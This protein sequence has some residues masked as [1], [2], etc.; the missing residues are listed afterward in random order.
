MKE[1]N[2]TSETVKVMTT[3]NEHSI[4]VKAATVEQVMGVKGILVD[5]GATTHIVKE[6]SKF[7]QL[8]NSC[9]PE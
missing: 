8:D 5:T 7:I 6:R 2:E 3:A 4:A 9:V 1:N